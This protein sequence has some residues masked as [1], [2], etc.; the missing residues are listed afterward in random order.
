MHINWAKMM[1]KAQQ[2]LKLYKA[3]NRTTGEIADI[4]GCHQAYVRVVA[5]QRRGIGY[6][7]IDKRYCKRKFGCGYYAKRRAEARA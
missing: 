1:T 6:S 2:I 7:E 5:R 3:G 4:V